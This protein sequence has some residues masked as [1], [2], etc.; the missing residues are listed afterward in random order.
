MFYF[1][2][3]KTTRV[4]PKVTTAKYFQF[5]NPRHAGDLAAGMIGAGEYRKVEVEAISQ[6]AYM[7][8]TRG[9]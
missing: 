1:K 7:R 2:I 8:A 5:G 4:V 6:A 3:T 9:K